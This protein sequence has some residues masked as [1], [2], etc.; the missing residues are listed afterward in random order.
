MAI[1]AVT[2]RSPHAPNSPSAAFDAGVAEHHDAAPHVPRVPR[3]VPD[4]RSSLGGIVLELVTREDG[5]DRLGVRER[6]RLEL[7]TG[8]IAEHDAERDGERIGSVF[9]VRKNATV[10]KL[11][12]LI[13]DP[14]ARGSGLGTTLVA[15]CVRFARACGY[16]RI[17]L[18][19][20]RNLIAARRIYTA[21]GFELVDTENHASFGVPLVGETWELTL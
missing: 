10:A 1:A 12:L 19:T 2:K 17:T 5:G 13:V 3:S 15:E 16:R 14:R 8:A 20:Q 11:R 6:Q 4:E 9:L 7:G 18:W 21:Q